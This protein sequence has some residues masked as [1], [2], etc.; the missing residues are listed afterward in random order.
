MVHVVDVNV[1]CELACV[2]YVINRISILRGVCLI[3][4]CGQI[5]QLTKILVLT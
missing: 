4:V 2:V 5:L 3:H 1:C